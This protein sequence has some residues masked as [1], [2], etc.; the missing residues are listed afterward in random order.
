[1]ALGK[2][3]NK[4]KDKE[5]KSL[6]QQAATMAKSGTMSGSLVSDSKLFSNLNTS[7]SKSSSSNGSP[8]SSSGGGS[9]TKSG[10]NMSKSEII[11]DLKR[12]TGD[13]SKRDTKDGKHDFLDRIANR[14]SNL[15]REWQ[16]RRN[17]QESSNRVGTWEL[18]QRDDFDELAEFGSG[19]RSRVNLADRQYGSTMQ[20]MSVREGGLATPE[21]RA[22]NA[23]YLREN[24]TNQNIY[25]YMTPLQRSTYNAFIGMGNRQGAKAYL[26]SIEAELTQQAA[27]K[28]Q[29]NLPD[30][31][32]QTKKEYKETHGGSTEGYNR[33]EEWGKAAN[34]ANLGVEAGVDRFLTGVEQLGNSDAV[35]KNYN[36]LLYNE[37]REGMSGRAG[38]IADLSN[39]IGFMLLP[40]AGS[41]VLGTV[42]IGTKVV[43][44]LSSAFFGVA[45][46]G[47]TYND[48]LTADP[49]AD[50]FNARAY[51]IVNG[52]LEG[53]LQHVLGGIG[54]FGKGGLSR[55]AGGA[56]RGVGLTE[57]VARKLLNV[58]KAASATPAMKALVKAV[59]AGG[60]GVGSASDEALEEWLQSVLD[61]LV[62]N[63]VLDENNQVQLFGEEQLY[64]AIMGALGSAVMNAPSNASNF[65]NAEQVLE[66]DI[67]K[68]EEKR[69]QKA[70]KKG[71]TTPVEPLELTPEQQAQVEGDEDLT[72]LANSI[73]K[74]KQDIATAKKRHIPGYQQQLAQRQ[75]ML[76]EL[77]A[78]KAAAQQQTAE[79]P[80]QQPIP[81]VNNA[82]YIGK[83]TAAAA[84]G[85]GTTQEQSPV[86]P[87]P[88]SKKGKK[89]KKG[90][91]QQ[92]TIAQ[93]EQELA[94]IDAELN[95]V[96]T[97]QTQVRERVSS[98]ELMQRQVDAAQ[99]ALQDRQSMNAFEGMSRRLAGEQGPQNASP[100]NW[101]EGLVRGTELVD[102]LNRP[103]ERQ[104]TTPHALSPADTRRQNAQ[105]QR[106]HM[107]SN[108]ERVREIIDQGEAQGKTDDEIMDDVWRSFDERARTN[109]QRSVP[110]EVYNR[111]MR[112][113][114][115]QKQYMSP[116]EYEARKQQVEDAYYRDAAE[117]GLDQ[118]QAD[119][120]MT[121]QRMAQSPADEI[122]RYALGRDSGNL[123]EDQQVDRIINALVERLIGQDKLDSFSRAEMPEGMEGR[124]RGRSIQVNKD[125]IGTA[126]EAGAVSHELGHLAAR[127][128]AELVPDIIK[129]MRQEGMDVESMV[130]ERRNQYRED[131]EALGL[132]FD[133]GTQDA[134]FFE[135]EVAMGFIGDLHETN[136]ELLNKIATEQPGLIQRIL[137]VLRKIADTLTGREKDACELTIER[138]NAALNS[139]SQTQQ[140][141]TNSRHLFG[142]KK[143]LKASKER[144]QRAQEMDAN[145]DYADRIWRETGW[146]KGEDNKWRFEI[147]DEF[148]RFYPKGKNHDKKV[149]DTGRLADFISHSELFE[150]YPDMQDIEVR[151]ERDPDMGYVAYYQPEGDYIVLNVAENVNDADVLHEIQHAIQE[152]E[153]FARGSSI[154]YW[155]ERL[156]N[157]D[158][159]IR[160]EAWHDRQI[161]AYLK[162]N[163][164]AEKYPE[165]EQEL[166]SLQELEDN[167]RTFFERTLPEN[168]TPD[169][170]EAA[171]AEYARMGDA[172]EAKY[173]ELKE[174]YGERL[175][176]EFDLALS[177]KTLDDPKKLN[178][179]A[180]YTQTAGEQEARMV[181]SRRN[182]SARL[183]EET[184]PKIHDKIDTVFVG[185][186]PS[187]F[188]PW[189]KVDTNG[190]QNA[191]SAAIDADYKSAIEQGDMETAQ[192]LVDEAAER[193]GYNVS[194]YHGTDAHFNEFKIGDIGYHIGT[195]GQAKS[196]INNTGLR[197]TQTDR[198][199]HVMRLYANIQNP[200]EVSFDAG[201]WSGKNLALALLEHGRFDEDYD[202]NAEEINARLSEI[203]GMSDGKHTDKVMRDY[204]KS[205]G[206]DGIVYENEFEDV[207][208]EDEYW[209]GSYEL[210]Y[211][212]FD[213]DQLK[214]ADP[215]TY[216]DNGDVIPLSE[217]FRTDRTGEEARK[218]NDV[219]YSL[220]RKGKRTKEHLTS[221]GREG[222]IPEVR[223]NL[224][225]L[226]EEDARY[227]QQSLTELHEET[228]ERIDRK[229]NDKVY[230]TLMNTRNWDAK[231]MNEAT[232]LLVRLARGGDTRSVQAMLP[233]YLTQQKNMGQ[234]INA[235]KLLRRYMPD[236]VGSITRSIADELDVELTKEEKADIDL[237]DRIIKQGFISDST[238]SKASPEF[239]E[240]L[241][242]AREYVDRGQ[243]DASTCAYA[244]AMTRVINKSP[245]TAREKYRALQR[246]SLL[247]NPKTHFRNI[248][249][250]LAEQTGAI[251][252]RPMADF[253]DRG[254]SKVTHRRTFGSGGGQAFAHAITDGVEK[255]LMDHVLG[256]NT[257]GNK[258][259]ENMSRS[260]I[261]QLA[262]K[263]VF[264]E[265]TKS[266]LHNSINK[267]A[268]EIDHLIGL[269]LSIGDAPFLLGTYESALTQIMN[270]NPDLLENGE[271]TPEMVETAWDVA[272]RRTFRDSNML[273]KSLSNIRNSLPFVG[274]TIAPYVQTPVNVVLTALEYSP[275][276]FAKALVDAFADI[277]LE[278]YNLGKHTS[279]RT[280]LKNNESTMKTQR[281][282]AEAVGRGSLG[283]AMILIGTLLR[284][285]GK[286]TPDDDDIESSKEKN[287][288]KATGRRGSSIKFGDKYVDP[289]SLQSLST[290]LMAGAAAYDRTE[291]G[292]IDWAGILGAAVKASMKMGNTMLEMPV[293]QGVADLFSGNYDNGEL[294]TGVLAMAGN[295]ATQIV[296]FGSLTRQVAK[297]VDP[298]SRAQSEINEGPFKRIAKNTVNNVAAMFPGTRELLPERYDVLG[299]PIKND[300]SKGIVGRAYNSFINPFNTSR[301]YSNEV[302]DEIDRLYAALQDTDV[303]PTAAGNSIS[304]GGEKYKFTSAE[305]QE[306]QRIEGESNMELLTSL[307]NSSAYDGLS[308]EEK[309][310]VIKSVYDYSSDKAKRTYLDA[311]GVEYGEDDNLPKW[312]ATIDSL[313]EQGIDIGSA[314]IYRKHLTAMNNKDEQ[315][316]YID[317]L[318][319]NADQKSALDEAFIDKWSHRYNDQ[320]RDY[321][322]EDTLNLSMTSDSSQR[323]YEARF[324]NGWYGSS[325]THYPGI[326]TKMYKDLCD[327]YWFKDSP[328][329]EESRQSIKRMLMEA[330]Y[331]MDEEEA[332][333]FSYDFR[334][335][336]GSTKD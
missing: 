121:S 96:G 17:Q 64:S 26:K 235:F 20:G 23:E 19:L 312:P 51:S 34:I 190:R 9:Y 143:A 247:S 292:D 94:E 52:A 136:P 13:Y 296:P 78:Q 212:A 163:E 161:D 238:I 182:L 18:Q 132:P 264:D 40:A 79:A 45:A 21:Q 41:A 138:L 179:Y 184:T 66:A 244:A 282:I 258:F 214:L 302:T 199:P 61:P 228:A 261:E 263:D 5:N 176:V 293:L 63:Y 97:P 135:E 147:N 58:S 125:L 37:A 269:G 116:E 91:T 72:D 262:Q 204:L 157:E 232:V 225:Q 76:Q 46:G 158:V 56:A 88:K 224:E 85:L 265:H 243:L 326:D 186:D 307:V 30:L 33:L 54:A 311:Q 251:M 162:Y 10:V 164:L 220:A 230:A 279:L 7:S 69:N 236:A 323:K 211:I 92:L 55:L 86:E 169:E 229:G 240:W 90:D 74:L 12:T 277:N 62:R 192:R 31:D 28:A 231:Q 60:K 123:T 173:D 119:S 266:K 297:T 129:I 275:V 242:E 25:D 87:A 203:A 223:E 3:K 174:K 105:D 6:H 298:Y 48:L 249:G 241:E 118:E 319:L 234:A 200:L 170:W 300:A 102:A 67:A 215:V 304:Y 313:V 144:W 306:F 101:Q 145:G 325:G 115:Y 219:R 47:G 268:N 14:T 284:A 320:V 148:M 267:V 226:S 171:F 22:Q 38:V 68:Q 202:E 191:S 227:V 256:I 151:I 81:A 149:G 153:N 328:K 193:A 239:K 283:T 252:S 95:P 77:L 197:S 43:Q 194:G 117:A 187:L 301:E 216:D 276:G 291:D 201:N 53:C 303:L 8:K 257:V 183:R 167:Q 209:D 11:E 285:A 245:S 334:K 2:N 189:E 128:D 4:D 206:Y 327:A 131:Y 195:E 305:K 196:R 250:N 146:I 36:E 333:Q 255:A 329:A 130:E 100:T 126:Q 114:E 35:A 127:M 137:E 272:Y 177:E 218:N 309:M 233:K 141:D 27:E 112:Y 65:F 210:S 71:S 50:K 108:T 317:S 120:E 133:E 110:M 59:V 154:G 29:E 180:L 109:A 106:E 155:Q 175:V 107:H 205:L 159:P 336:Y 49:G 122:E 253:V 111:A 39:N 310:D 139:T 93:L 237:C 208:M 142:G 160:T 221:E 83:D 290:P 281:R 246:I 84:N 254:I 330:P 185:D 278:A 98:D 217:R 113:L 16:D 288:N 314:L 150:N 103:R 152:R 172:I 188:S 156:E 104:E 274:E 280:Q 299:N 286:I 99:R 89:G 124:Q 248:L 324:K 260:G 273:T 287:W 140:T 213:S 222:T 80:T 165:L 15:R 321:T 75:Q 134:A 181:E 271:A 318:D 207:D 294:L 315:V 1:M 295:A 42:G 73:A 166:I 198:E 322:N 44:A 270:A 331:Y 178:P 259:D 316:Y 289:S 332:D 32:Y 24:T 168:Y 70:A 82:P 335:R 308:D 57:A